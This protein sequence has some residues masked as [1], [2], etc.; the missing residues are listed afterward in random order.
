MWQKNPTHWKCHFLWPVSQVS[1][2][3]CNDHN[4]QLGNYLRPI[5]IFTFCGWSTMSNKLLFL[6][7]KN[8]F[9]LGWQDNCLISLVF[10]WSKLLWAWWLRSMSLALESGGLGS[11]PVRGSNFEICRERWIYP[12]WYIFR[13]I[14]LSSTNQSA[15]FSEYKTVRYDKQ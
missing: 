1:E 10:Y 7:M 2:F 9:H 14:S 4:K 13:N 6:R 8:D 15:W 12:R 5:M 11:I 3:K